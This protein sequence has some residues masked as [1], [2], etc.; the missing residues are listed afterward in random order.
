M[1]RPPPHAPLQRELV[2]PVEGAVFT[3][4]WGK[5]SLR[6]HGGVVLVGGDLTTGGVVG[7]ALVQGERV[8]GPE[9]VGVSGGGVEDMRAQQ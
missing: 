1:P 5:Q 7:V 8:I 4:V 2:G 3:Q 9:Q 6:E